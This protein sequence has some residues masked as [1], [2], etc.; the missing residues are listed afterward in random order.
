[1]GEIERV[2]RLVTY[3]VRHFRTSDPFEI[4]DRKL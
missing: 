3:Y 4:A 1:M 2:K